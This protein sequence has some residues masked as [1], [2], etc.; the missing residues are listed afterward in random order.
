VC[1]GSGFLAGVCSTPNDLAAGPADM[2]IAADLSV[3][4]M[5]ASTPSTPS[6]SGGGLSCAYGGAQPASSTEGFALLLLAALGLLLRRAWMKRN[7]G[8]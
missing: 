3:P 6:L 2:S 4:D 5:S 1:S 8:I 7:N